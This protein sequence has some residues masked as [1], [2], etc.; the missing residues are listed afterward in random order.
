MIFYQ[1]KHSAFIIFLYILINCRI[2]KV[3]FTVSDQKQTAWYFYEKAINFRHTPVATQKYIIRWVR[4]NFSGFL[5]RCRSCIVKGNWISFFIIFF[6]LFLRKW[7]SEGKLTSSSNCI[8]KR[9][10]NRPL[11][12]FLHANHMTLF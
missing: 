3:S 4:K 9:D 11:Q 5:V 6:R 7:C 2:V 10:R 12:L 1:M 8:W